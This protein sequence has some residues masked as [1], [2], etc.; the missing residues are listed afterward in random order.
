MTAWWNFIKTLYAELRKGRACGS[1]PLRARA[2]K[3]LKTCSDINGESQTG[4]VGPGVGPSLRSQVTQGSPVSGAGSGL[5]R[6]CFSPA[7]TTRP[8]KIH[9]QGKPCPPQSLKT[10]VEGCEAREREHN[11]RARTSVSPS[12]PRPA[13][14]KYHLNLKTSDAL[15]KIQK[16]QKPPKAC[17]TETRASLPGSPSRRVAGEGGKRGWQRKQREAAWLKSVKKSNANLMNVRSGTFCQRG[18]ES[19]KGKKKKSSTAANSPSTKFWPRCRSR[20]AI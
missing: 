8:Q 5:A 15:K 7:P 14:L 9:S 18:R 4:A 2:P 19:R 13:W 3:R 16:T 20:A 17:P 12:T 1:F 11:V 6:A 10:K